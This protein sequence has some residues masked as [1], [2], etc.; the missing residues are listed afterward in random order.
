MPD[1]VKGRKQIA[2]SRVRV[3]LLIILALLI[4]AYGVYRIGSL[5]NL[6][7]KRYQ[8]VTLV[9]SAAGLLK[10]AQVTLAGQ[11]VGLVDG[12]DFIPLGSHG[13]D[14]LMVH[15]S[16]NR[17]VQTYIRTNS[18]ARI[19]T[20]GALGD[21]YIDITPGTL[22]HRVLQPGDTIPGIAAIEFEDILATASATLTATQGLVGDLRQVVQRLNRGEGTLGLM[23]NDPTLYREMLGA[24][25]QLRA[26]L[27]EIQRADG[28]LG[29][30]IRDPA[31]YEQVHGAVARVDSLG[32]EILHGH[33]TLGQLIQSDSLY[34]AL[35]GVAGRADSALGTI[36][37]L[38]EGE[39]TVQR[40]LTD[41]ALYDQFLKAV[42]DLQTL[43]DDIRANPKKYRPEVKVKVF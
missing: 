16:I 40:L 25:T 17:K 42:I 7:T 4:V 3:G 20:Q 14:H 21:K 6:F 5:Y 9:P 8:L 22:G 27:T 39:G 30:L 2:W 10:G 11:R 19:R 43:I 18:V 24:T 38:L 32:M 1:G 41:P 12:I 29:R 13:N 36:T 33:G 28:T 34:R 35:Y 37:R 23:L 26:L 31:L 15:L